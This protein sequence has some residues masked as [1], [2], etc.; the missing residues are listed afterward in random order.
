METGGQD[1]R[2]PATTQRVIPQIGSPPP[3]GL[4]QE[5][6]DLTRRGELSD[7]EHFGQDWTPFVDRLLTQLRRG[8]H[9]AAQQLCHMDQKSQT[10]VDEL[11]RLRNTMQKYEAEMSAMKKTY[12]ERLVDVSSTLAVSASSFSEPHAAS[13]VPEDS[14]R[15][16]AEVEFSLTKK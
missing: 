8:C 1:Q 2:N 10:V 5:L 6:Q 9:D 4:D 13:L 15:D 3:S 11:N 12:S 14:L 16:Q 7:P